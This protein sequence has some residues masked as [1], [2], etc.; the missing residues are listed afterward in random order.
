M[1]KFERGHLR[2]EG[3]GGEEGRRGGGRRGGGEE[4]GAQCKDRNWKEREMEQQGKK[5]GDSHEGSL[6]ETETRR[7][8]LF[9]RIF[10]L[11]SSHYF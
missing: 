1:P 7:V 10:T 3:G 4:E 5:K 11:S 9:F 8:A 2:Q 6:Y